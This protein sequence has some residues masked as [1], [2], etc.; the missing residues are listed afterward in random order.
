MAVARRILTGGGQVK[1][2]T[3]MPMVRKWRLPSDK[4]NKFAIPLKLRGG[5]SFADLVLHSTAP[6]RVFSSTGRFVP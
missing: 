2:F 4:I 6:C 1:E 5:G 3:F